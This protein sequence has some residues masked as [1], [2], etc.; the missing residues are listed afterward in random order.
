MLKSVQGTW[1]CDGTRTG[2]DGKPEKIKM[3]MARKSDLDG[4]WIHDSISAGPVKT[5]DFR[6]EA[7]TTYDATAKHWR[8]VWVMSE[9][10]AMTGTGGAMTGT[11]E[12]MKDMKMDFTYEAV[13]SPNAGSFHEHIDA[14]DMHKGLHLTGEASTD[15]GKTWLQRFDVVCRR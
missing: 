6:A 11:G 12:T 8:R 1:S 13:D 4:F 2:S 10:G 9:G 15:K 3:T 5:P 7:F 14:S